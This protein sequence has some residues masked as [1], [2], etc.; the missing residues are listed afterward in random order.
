VLSLISAG[1][2]THELS[3]FVGTS[4]LIVSIFSLS[5]ILMT[6]LPREGIVQTIGGLRFSLALFWAIVPVV[7]A[8]TCLGMRL[9][10][11]Q[12]MVFIAI[13]LIP[14]PVATLLPTFLRKKVRLNW[15]PK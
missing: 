2:L 1:V 12:S 14:I 15:D 7:T 10:L 6:Q 11:D 8:I 5:R 9:P 13:G 3:V 4:A